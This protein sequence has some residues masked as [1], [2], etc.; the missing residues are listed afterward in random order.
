MLS[1]MSA[2]LKISF[3]SS[4]TPAVNSTRFSLSLSL[5]EMAELENEQATDPSLSPLL[6]CLEGSGVVLMDGGLTTSLPAQATSHA[7]W[8]H[9]LLLGVDGGLQSLHDVHLSHLRSGAQVLSTMTYKLSEKFIQECVIKGYLDEDIQEIGDWVK[10][11][12]WNPSTVSAVQELY[13]R[14]ISTA[15]KAV[16]TYVD[17][18]SSSGQVVAH[19]PQVY[20]SCGPVGDSR[21]FSGVTD[22]DS[23]L[24]LQ[25]DWCRGYYAEKLVG[26]AGCAPDG[27]AV[28]SIPTLG[29]AVIAAEEATKASLQ[30]PVHI[31]FI[32]KDESTTMGGSAFSECVATLDKFS[33]VQSIG[34]NCTSPKYMVPLIEIAARSTSKPISVY[35]NSGERFIAKKGERRWVDEGGMKVVCG[36][37]AVDYYKAGARIIGGCCRVYATQIAEMKSSLQEYRSQL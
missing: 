28:E 14:A 13:H 22:P 3:V 12:P 33:V 20:A 29:E 11:S 5:Y 8:G 37:D 17:E 34:I 23:Q 21:L 4:I 25:E 7:L 26:L 36:Q 27:I 6:K 1:F 2:E 15:K 31:T 35:P 30:I 18:V 19:R 16:T 32:C 9:Q 10:T 24:T